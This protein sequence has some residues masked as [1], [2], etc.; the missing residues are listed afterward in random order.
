MIFLGQANI[1]TIGLNGKTNAFRSLPINPMKA[2]DTAQASGFIKT[3]H[4]DA[5]V[6]KWDLPG[7]PNGIFLKR[8]KAFKPQIKTIVLIQAGN[9]NQEI[10]ARCAGAS[11][12]LTEG[13]S[14]SVLRQT[15]IDALRI[16]E[17]APADAVRK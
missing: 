9:V 14:E 17:Y 2:A 5:V 16:H 13:T 4:I 15:I 3:E 11:V 6:C 8:L 7:M 1:L 10:A 12:V